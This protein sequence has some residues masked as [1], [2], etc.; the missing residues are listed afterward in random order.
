MDGPILVTGGTGTLGRVVVNRLR[1]AGVEARALSRRPGAAPGRVTGD[2]SSGA[3]IA[4]A[5]RGCPVIVH[6][7]TGPRRDTAATHN[8]IGAARHADVIPH[9]VYIS[10]V[11]VDR[12]LADAGG[13]PGRG[14]PGVLGYYR[15]KL[16]T[17]QLVA[18][19]GVPWTILRATQFHDLLAWVFSGLSR[20]PV[21]PVLAATS[22]QPVDVGDVADRLVELATTAPAGRVPDIGGP[23]VRPMAD[24]ARAWLAATGR[25]RLVLPMRLPGAAARGFREGGHLAPQHRDGRRTFEEYLDAAPAGDR[26]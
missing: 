25:R 7:A 4:E 1:A 9:L 5:V 19:A 21:L 2:L 11:G 20:S 15:E 26:S 6:C 3:G 18:Q 13:R 23:Q 8:L 14:V 12:V 16:A 24:L 17:E 10:I 22:F